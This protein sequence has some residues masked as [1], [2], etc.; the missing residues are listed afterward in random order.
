M[1]TSTPP[2]RHRDDPRRRPHV[3]PFARPIHPVE[4]WARV[5]LLDGLAI[6]FIEEHWRDDLADHCPF[7]ME[8]D[9]R[10]PGESVSLRLMSLKT[11][12]ISPRSP[13]GDGVLAAEVRALRRAP[14]PDAD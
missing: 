8:P 2:R 9:P 11:G 1:T 12:E 6:Q 3:L 5:F 10:R 7:P 4:R 14:G 13:R